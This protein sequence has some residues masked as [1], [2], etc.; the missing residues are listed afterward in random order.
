MASSRKK[1]V[2][3]LLLVLALRLPA[4]LAASR[5]P[6]RTLWP[7][8]AGYLSLTHG[9]LE[10]EGYHDAQNT[11][12]DL[13]R[14]PGYPVF[15]ASIFL[16]FGESMAWVVAVQLLLSVGVG[17]ML[18][19]LG[20]RIGS[21]GA[22]FVSGILYAVSLN[23]VLWALA[24]LS[25][26]LFV[27]LVMLAF[28]VFLQGVESR[29]FWRLGLGGLLL[30][31]ATLTRPIGLL[32][33]PLWGVWAVA[34][35]PC[36]GL[37]GRRGRLWAAAAIF[38]AGSLVAVLPWAYR[39]QRVRG[40]FNVS[41]IAVWNLGRYQAPEALARAEGLTLEEARQR[42]PISRIPQEGDVRRFL[43]VI[44]A[45]PRAYLEA[46]L[47]GT[48]RILSEV[49]Q[50]NLA[51]LLGVSYT[52]SGV[53]EALKQGDVSAALT[54]FA[55]VMQGSRRGWMFVAVVWSL[56]VQALT[57]GLALLGAAL[58]LRKS[59]PRRWLALLVMLTV[60][61]FLLTPG[62]V[63][64]GRFRLPAEPFMDLL[65]GVGGLRL[66]TASKRGIRALGISSAARLQGSR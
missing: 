57:Y 5:Y 49:G 35:R 31:L 38:V 59:G 32:M 15:L 54:R 64:N 40:V 22:G 29:S 61:A 14:T 2:L 9:L 3:I 24:I 46:H 17:L 36:W 28:L 4:V 34:C 60:A 27:F 23:P 58:L 55:S 6:E 11:A 19:A 52:G 30:G 1:M 26:T 66:F 45:Y 25:D 42:I 51:Q 18:L 47:E 56:V 37:E 48:R 62:P 63:G 20:R 16:A 21:E 53:F 44:L 65:A 41:S 7:D 8:S 39:N 50:P 43:G 33:I 13:V 10:G 12:W